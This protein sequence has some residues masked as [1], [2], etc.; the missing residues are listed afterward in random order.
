M[1]WVQA[2]MEGYPSVESQMNVS[3]VNELHSGGKKGL[4]KLRLGGQ[5]QSKPSRHRGH[6][7]QT[8]KR[9]RGKIAK[10]DNMLVNEKINGI[11]QNAKLKWLRFLIS[12]VGGMTVKF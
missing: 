12:P 5:S 2:D 7:L 1:S 9:K 3:S 8:T 6:L 11:V 4:I 10:E